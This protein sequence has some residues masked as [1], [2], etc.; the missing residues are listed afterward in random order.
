MSAAATRWAA[1][2]HAEA[3]AEYDQI[4]QDAGQYPAEDAA[5][6]LRTRVSENQRRE[7]ANTRRAA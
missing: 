5:L 4:R 2:Y 1:L 6:A 3:L 7:A